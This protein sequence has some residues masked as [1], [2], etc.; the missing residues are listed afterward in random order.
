MAPAAGNPRLQVGAAIVVALVTLVG[1]LRFDW[2]VFVVMLLYWAE[3]VLIGIANVVRL[4]VAGARGGV[5]TLLGGLFLA[6]FFTL[7]YGI[8][9]GVHGMFVFALFGPKPGA[10]PVDAARDMAG[11]VALDGWLLLALAVMAAGVAAD[12]LRWI[13]ISRGRPQDNDLGQ[14]MMSPYG[15]VVVLHLTLLIGAG[16]MMAL[17]A[18]AAAVILLVVLK[19]GFDLVRLT[20]RADPRAGLTPHA[21]LRSARLRWK[22]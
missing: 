13:A 1:V 12:T 5:G 16:L 17:Q 2:P 18:P 4:L 10:D 14:L 3:N 9:T 22:R 20:R 19:L 8:F 6:G 21:L 15:R 7:H 11:A